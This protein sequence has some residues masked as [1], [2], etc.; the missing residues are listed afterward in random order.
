MQAKP[1]DLERVALG[2]VHTVGVLEG[3]IHHPVVLTQEL[4]G[5]EVEP[6]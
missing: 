2:A 5:P 3:S 6:E 1:L 4:F